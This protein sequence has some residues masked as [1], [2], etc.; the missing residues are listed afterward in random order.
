MEDSEVFAV[1]SQCFVDGGEVE[2]DRFVAE[3]WAEFCEAVARIES[4]G[5]G[6]E[7]APPKVCEPALPAPPSGAE[8]DSY[9][10]RR[11]TGGLPSSAMPVESLYA[12]FAQTGSGAARYRALCAD[13]MA[14]VASRMGL[15][16][17]ER[18]AAYPD[19]LSLELDLIA[20]LLR[21]DALDSARTV[22]VE[23]L[24]WLPDYRADLERFDDAGFYRALLDRLGRIRRR[25]ADEK[26]SER[27]HY[28]EKTLITNIQEG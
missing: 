28:D 7:G 25:L 27:F 21:A 3:Q 11:Y 17:P 18:F 16:I 9:A 20:V 15:F 8:K 23:R 5:F 13:Y 19:H 22:A 2:W 26:E 24:A 14:D 10:R 4:F 1:L 6:A 12:S